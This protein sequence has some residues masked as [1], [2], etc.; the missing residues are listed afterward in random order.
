MF[1]S[2]P[3]QSLEWTDASVEGVARFLRRLWTFGHELDARAAPR[4]AR[5]R[6]D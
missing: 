6:R 2:P 4:A 3:E 5:R 1:A